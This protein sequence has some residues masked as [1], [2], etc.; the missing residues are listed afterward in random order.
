MKTAA[1]LPTFSMLALA[2]SIAPAHAIPTTFVSGTGSGTACTR[3]APCA[4]FLAAHDATDAGGQI[5]CLDAGVFPF[6]ATI[7]KSITIDCSGTVGAVASAFRIN[8]PGGVVRL[9][10]LSFRMDSVSNGV[11]FL[12][13]AALFV[14]NCTFTDNTASVGINFEPRS[15]TAKLFVTNT[16][17]MNHEGIVIAPQMSAGAQVVLDRVRVEK[18][19]GIGIEVDSVPGGGPVVVQIRNS[20]LANDQFGIRANPPNGNTNPIVSVTFDRGAMIY[21]HVAA[22]TNGSSSFITLGRSSVTSN[23]IG[24]ASG[25]QIKSYQNNHLSGNVSDGTVS[26]IST[27]K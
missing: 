7:T 18:S 16:T 2:V 17:F 20:V 4:S 19:D 22:E 8:A 11:V 21:N 13:G 25:G 12:D 10:G 27:L 15:G 1:L 24:L 23:Q 26:A 3:T 6:A 9:R 14:E 5:I